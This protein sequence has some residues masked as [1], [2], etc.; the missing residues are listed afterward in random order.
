MS[1]LPPSPLELVTGAVESAETPEA[2]ETVLK[3]LERAREA[4]SLRSA[5]RAYHLKVSFAVNPG[6]QT[7][8]DGEWTWEQFFDP[9]LGSRRTAKS[10]SGYTRTEVDTANGAYAE[11]TEGIT[12]PLRLHEAR[13][14]L[15]GSIGTNL[16]QKAIRT[17]NVDDGSSRVICVLLTEPRNTGSAIIG[18][19]WEERE[20]CIDSQ[21]GLLRV[22]SQAPG[23]YY[24][25]A[26]TDAPRLADRT[27]PR[28]LTITEAGRVVSEIHVD[29]LTELPAADPSWFVPT[30]ELMKRGPTIAV[31]EARRFWPAAIPGVVSPG[32][33][34][35]TVCVF[36]L[37]TPTGELVEVH[38]LQPSDPN[39]ETALKIANARRFAAPPGANGRPEQRF[40]FLIQ[41]FVPSR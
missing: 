25:Y 35:Q 37:M 28:K 34:S 30:E 36:G 18:R 4:Y 6:N 8:Y 31:A 11:G 27:L 17:A 39:S 22:S 2:R 14:A 29:E 13:A 20:E 41:E 5:G 40:V 16:D 10:S 26:Y 33:A 15:L 7:A 23:R 24:T 38:S 32:N 1:P 12:V 9:K 21:S 19:R 3:L